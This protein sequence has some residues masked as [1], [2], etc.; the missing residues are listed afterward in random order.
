MKKYKINKIFAMCMTMVCLWP[1]I[2]LVSSCSNH[3]S[4]SGNLVIDGA[5]SNSINL[6]GNENLYGDHDFQARDNHGNIYTDVIWSL[7]GD[8]DVLSFL[9]IDKT[10]GHM[11]WSNNLEGNKEYKFQ[12]I[13]SDQYKKL[14]DAKC[15][16]NLHVSNDTSID[17]CPNSWFSVSHGV[18]SLKKNIDKNL[19][20]KV[21]IPSQI[22][23]TSIT[24]IA[25]GAFSDCVNLQSVHLCDSITTI[26]AYAFKNCNS[27]TSFDLNNVEQLGADTFIECSSLQSVAATKVKNVGM[28][29]FFNCSSLASVN[30]PVVETIGNNG[31]FGCS[32]I[33]SITLGNTLNFVGNNAFGNCS[34]ISSITYTSDS[35][36]NPNSFVLV[37]DQDLENVAWMGSGEHT[38]TNGFLTRWQNLQQ[39]SISSV[40][41][42]AL[43]QIKSP[44]GCGV[45]TN[46]FSNCGSIT[47]IHF[48]SS[49]ETQEVGALAFANCGVRWLDLNRAFFN[50]DSSTAFQGCK[51][52]NLI[53]GNYFSNEFGPMGNNVTNFFAGLSEMGRVDNTQGQDYLSSGD[54]L[55]YCW[56]YNHL[57]THWAALDKKN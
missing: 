42:L 7:S 8:A 48:N 50:I 51:K 56:A 38:I 19:V 53:T 33:A 52:C 20:R 54:L 6:N 30:L 44:T 32:S 49:M 26:D 2:A 17:V 43:G 14:Q 16:V 39:Q 45:E 37:D 36:Y 13:C 57:P 22:D 5:E 21:V 1:T 12:V 41:C 10:S 29:C 18:L 4:D 27:L 9:K 25:F 15:E 55:K 23:W 28:E 35:A 47:S 34:S 40:G 46:G 31:F 3:K 11:Q 24:E